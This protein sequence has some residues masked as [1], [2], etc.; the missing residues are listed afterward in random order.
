MLCH[1]VDD[2]KKKG[3]KESNIV[4]GRFVAR[5]KKTFMYFTNKYHQQFFSKDRIDFYAG[6]GNYNGNQQDISANNNTSKPGFS[7]KGILISLGRIWRFITVEPLMLCW[8]LPSCFLFIAVEN[9]AL[10]KVN[11]IQV[12]LC[13][14]YWNYWNI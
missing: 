13:W 14:K 7:G 12:K 2:M 5:K 9:L 6:S 11:Q 3:K 4:T 10:E 8:L 1:S